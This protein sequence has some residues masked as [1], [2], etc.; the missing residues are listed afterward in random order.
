MCYICATSASALDLK[1][2]YNHFIHEVLLC[3][4]KSRIYHV[5]H[6]G[7]EAGYVCVHTMSCP[8]DNVFTA[9]IACIGMPLNIDSIQV[10]VNCMSALIM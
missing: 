4:I 9:C 1:R 2:I 5:G 6:S 10:C 7:I 8:V 3:P